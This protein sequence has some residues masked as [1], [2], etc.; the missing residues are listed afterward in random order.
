MLAT[1]SDASPAAAGA[2]REIGGRC[3]IERLVITLL[4]VLVTVLAVT[5][6][7]AGAALPECANSRTCTDA[8]LRTQVL[9][10]APGLDSALDAHDTERAAQLLLEWA[11]PR[12]VVSGDTFRTSTEGRSAADIYYGTFAAKT[13]GAFCYEAADFY[14]KLLALFGIDSGLLIYGETGGMEHATVVVRVEQGP[15]P[16]FAL[17]DPTFGA[18]LRRGGKQLASLE[19]LVRSWDSP[20]AEDFR[21]ER[22]DLSARTWLD[23]PNGTPHS[24]SEPNHPEI[25]ACDLDRFVAANAASFRAAGLPTG[26]RGFLEFLV[27]SIW[28]PPEWSR[29]PPALVAVQ[30]PV[31]EASMAPVL[32]IVLLFVVVAWFP[33][34]RRLATRMRFRPRMNAP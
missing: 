19:D 27:L 4:A 1:F 13:G 34:R 25:T 21:L 11:A 33:V 31:H 5:V 9:S 2:S 32:G 17:F 28:F 16:V 3:S 29:I 22:I 20:A 23:E 24:C 7:P 26:Q 12:I 8:D 6:G 30:G 10:E 14:R 15:S 18:V